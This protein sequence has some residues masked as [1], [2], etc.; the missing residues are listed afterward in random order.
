MSDAEAARL[1]VPVFEFLISDDARFLPA[2]TVAEIV[3]AAR[4]LYITLGGS[5]RRVEG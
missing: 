3:A 4:V 2:Q 5:V 1:T